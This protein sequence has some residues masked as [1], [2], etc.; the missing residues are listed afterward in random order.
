IDADLR[1]PALTRYILPAPT[2]GLSDILSGDT[3]LDHCL[4]ELKSSHLTVLPSG[5]VSFNPL[6]LLQSD[7]LVSILGELR[8][9]FDRIVIDTPP[10]VPFT[11]AAVLNNVSDGAL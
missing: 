7:Y 4:I 6:E 9:R 2:L 10:T 3:S 8:R 5:A 11:D 1:R